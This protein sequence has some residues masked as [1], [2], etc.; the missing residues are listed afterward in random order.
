[1]QQFSNKVYFGNVC[2]K[3]LGRLLGLFIIKPKR[4]E[5]GGKVFIKIGF[6]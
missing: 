5:L 2:L 3:Q 4:L 1:M 6:F